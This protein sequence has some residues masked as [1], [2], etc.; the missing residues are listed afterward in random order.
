DGVLDKVAQTVEHTWPAFADRLLPRSALAP[1]LGRGGHDQLGAE[2]AIGASRLLD[3]LGDAHA[4]V[5]RVRLGRSTRQLFENLSTARGLC[6]QQGQVL[7]QLAS[8]RCVLVQLFSD[9]RDGRK[10]CTEL[11]CSGG[12]K[13]VERVQL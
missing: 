6:L 5:Q 8:L 7:R 2:A 9:N 1:G 3:Q 12:G 13:T 10:R 11:V 4:R